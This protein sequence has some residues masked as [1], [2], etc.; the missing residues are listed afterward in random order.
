M[1]RVLV[2][3][4]VS[5]LAT[6]VVATE[7]R[8]AGPYTVSLVSPVPPAGAATFGWTVAGTAPDPRQEITGIEL[9]GCWTA[10]QV[11]SVEARDAA[12]ASLRAR[13][14][15]GGRTAGRIEVSG[16]SDR[17]L[18]ATITATFRN[19]FGSAATGTAAIIESGKGGQTT[20]TNME[21]G[22]PTCRPAYRL[23]LSA[24]TGGRASASP[25]APSYAADTAVTITAVPDA[26]HEFSGWTVDG[27]AG[28]VANP[29]QLTMNADRTV[30]AAFTPSGPPPDLVAPPLDPSVPTSVFD[31]TSFLY[32]GPG[33]VQVGVAPGTIQPDRVAVL[34]GKVLT[35]DGHPLPGARITVLDHPEFGRTQSRADG[36]FDLA[37]N[38]GG[39]L[40]LRYEMAGVI[41]AQRHVDAPW[42]D[43]ASLPD[44]VLVP[45]DPQVT[46]I[47]LS[48]SEPTQVARGTAVVD[49]SG[50]RQATLVFSQGTTAT[51]KMPD[52]S[53]QPLASLD[54]R[55]TELTVGDGG[56]ERMPSELP[57]TSGYTYA[58]EFS[59]DA[60]V[61]AGATEVA[62][63][64]PVAFYVDNFLGFPAG[65]D[66]PVGYYDRSRAAWVPAD[67]GR[68][69]AIVGEND[70][71]A[72]VDVNG[73]GAADDTTTLAELG[74][75]DAER[76]RLAD[77]Y[78]PGRSLWRA[79][80]VH[81]SPYD[82]N[83]P[84]VPPPDAIGPNGGPPRPGG[85]SDDD[86]PRF[87]SIISCL[88]QGL[89][90]TI[91]VV[92]TPFSLN[93]QS[94]QTPGRKPA[95]V[96]P[97]SGDTIPA[98]VKYIE[99][100]VAVAG[101][102]FTE[103]FPPS[104]GASVNFTWDGK[105][106]YGR[107][108]QGEQWVSVEVAYAYDGVY[109]SPDYV[110]RSWAQFGTA[111]TNI[112]TRNEVAISEKW[113]G[114]F[115]TLDARA[116]GLGGWTLSAHHAYDP[117]SGTLH[118][119]N[120][121][122]TR[123]ATVHRVIDT[124]AGNGQFGFG[125]DGE[126]AT[127]A[128]L[129]GPSG[130]VVAPDGS[131]YV[132]D[133][134][135]HRVR[136]V[137]TSGVITT[138]AGTGFNGFSGDG[139]PATQAT[140]NSPGPLALGPDG[141][142]YVGDVLNFRIRR[143]SP[144]GTITTF[145]GGGSTSSGGGVPA[146]DFQFSVGGLAVGPDGA[147]YI[148][149]PWHPGRVFKVSLDGMIATVAGSLTSTS[150]GD[151][152]PAT[153]ARLNDPFALAVDSDGT[154][155]IGENGQG[156]TSRPR[157]RKVGTDGVISTYAGGGTADPGDGRPATE[158]VIPTPQGLAI[159]PDG[160]YIASTSAQRLRL[161]TRD[162]I[163]T[164][165]AGTGQAGFAGDG[166][167]AGAALLGSP[168]KV[169]VAP[170]G[171]IYFSESVNHRVRR[172][173][174]PLAGVGHGEALVPAPDGE[175]VFHFDA[176]GRHTRTLDGLTGAVLVQFAYDG[177]GRLSGVTDADG[178]VTSIDRLPDGGP[179]AIVAPGGQRTVLEVN[180][181]GYLVRVANP[182]N[183]AVVL[184]YHPGGL[185]ATLTEPRGGIHRYTYDG[186]GRLVGDEHP[187]GGVTTLARTELADGHRVTLRSP[188][189]L[190]TTYESHRTSY[191]SEHVTTDPAGAGT[192]NRL[193]TSSGRQEVTYPDGRT[194]ALAVG[195][196]PRFGMQAP[197]T[198]TMTVRTPGGHEQTL[199]ASRSV[200][201]A[202]PSDPL[203]L[204]SLT[205]TS[206]LDGRTST[207][208]YDG[209]T[210]TLTLRTPEGRE[211]SMTFDTRANVTA[212]HSAPGVDPVLYTY[213]PTGLLTQVEAGT[214]RSAYEYD[215][216]RRP[217]RRTGADGS[218]TLYSY[219][220]ADRVVSTTAP[221]GAV[222]TYR[223]DANGNR[224]GLT[225]PNGAEHRLAYDS[226]NLRSEYRAPGNGPEAW[227]HD[228]DR[229]LTT[230]TRP[231]G[232]SQV[233]TFDPGGRIDGTTTP[234]ASTATAYSDGTDRASGA[235]R[236]PSAVGMGEEVGFSYDGALLT[237]IDF[238]GPA[239]LG[240]YSYSHDDNGLVR[241]ARFDSG[242]QS[243]TFDV[244]RDGDGLVTA[245]GP[246][247]WA[248]GGPGG[249]VS[250]VS[251]GTL[252]LEQGYDG[253][254]NV[255]DRRFSVGGT[256]RYR[257]RSTFDDRALI[258]QRVET[259][260]GT[261]H[262]FEYVYDANQQLREVKR[263]AATVERYDYDV[264]ANRTSRQLG[265][266]PPE[267]AVYDAQDR[268]L[269]RG[270]V[271]YQVDDDGMLVR[272]GDDTF[273]YGTEGELVS[274]HVGDRIL[275]YSY[276]ALGRRVAKEVSSP[277]GQS[278][279]E[280]LY[281]D[282]GDPLLVTAVRSGA[283]LTV[284]FH[285][286]AGWLYAFER[287]GSRY[288]VASDHVGS[289]RLVTTAAGDVVKAVEYDAFGGVISDSNPDF[290]LPV[291]FAG[292]LADAEAG[293]VHFGF[294]DY[295]PASGRW[296]ARDPALFAGGQANLYAYVGNS[297]VT[298][299]D[300]SGLWCIGGSVYATVGVGAKVCQDEKGWTVCSEAGVG[301]GGGL[302]FD[303][304]GEGSN[305]VNLVGEIGLECTGVSL[306]AGLDID[307]CGKGKP[308]EP[309]VKCQV[310]LY[311]PCQKKGVTDG[312]EDAL[313]AIKPKC[314]GGGKLAIE[315]CAR[316]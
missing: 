119:G 50:T 131:L 105:D 220:A 86:C 32:S 242:G 196:D 140:L 252:A 267:A 90:E 248:R 67:D 284:L 161:V 18:P 302:E 179:A 227:V 301:V 104:A 172:I 279:V 209:A 292:G 26:G 1:R 186:L 256:E 272:R 31:A 109:T 6:M 125:G 114:S 191:G 103:S 174:R 37:V 35:P 224:T 55:A 241:Q 73:D 166:G 230:H 240:R 13:V 20:S 187:A 30:V 189:G 243:F 96:V 29:L 165:V 89:G 275:T 88:G 110:F 163:I 21:V 139:G 213:G 231:G 156:F 4:A 97:L 249:A 188:L 136:R 2:T 204:Q 7:A 14:R 289:P 15:G 143:I 228:L 19:A 253:H 250:R 72:D 278:R 44:V 178:N 288:Y 23:N 218:V 198:T 141:S 157:V 5:L 108:P 117:V 145:A 48:S 313:H 113:T 132:A 9:S 245:F 290:F 244:G 27:A 34:R 112:P 229:R 206:T 78:D 107:T 314:G 116:S 300:P 151:G 95:L 153:Q 111:L 160:L 181:D 158:A 53:T 239:S 63:S 216:L 232:R 115:G 52:G 258:T 312:F 146:T 81:F 311:D 71:Q 185:L 138:V 62:F 59:V 263:D 266:A 298:F 257:L 291:G 295:E 192:V 254:A 221:N 99:L 310:V 264:N 283:E 11:A 308:P 152:G 315:A 70:G 159:G 200:T 102:T 197:R 100:T 127:S 273:T 259:V 255:T 183:E 194:V 155:Y 199:S 60:A 304:F 41:P 280:Y 164:T 101:R 236:T 176:D 57:P 297:P 212:K 180:G 265:S 40:T 225:M 82:L 237:S 307:L 16:V 261:T 87:S 316:I 173:T 68:V 128:M 195:P 202:N 3:L 64:K 168:M 171:A 56:P 270:A 274:A 262:T 22:G 149:E 277:A 238:R 271:A 122:R 126:A 234:E 36:M 91:D 137:D 144:G 93:Y 208:S 154:L 217:V 75:D 177:A 133:S 79:R 106:A 92:G 282:P 124:V 66:V 39:R 65:T 83:F 12:G 25:E 28:G 268:L 150:L 193:F 38:G 205:D 281:G 226:M 17:R 293:L 276:D 299:R 162:G 233:R 182:A 120:G 219:D 54:V 47:D 42:E 305:K 46:T 123:A 246:F 235:T 45:F 207:R 303:P 147:V 33:A 148:S 24:S 77:L 269:S 98:S 142:L 118:Y 169:D 306:G 285:D 134:G 309:K 74:L 94:N 85:G 129:R 58:A 167:P 130:V 121:T 251:G 286:D 61:S 84:Y 222:Y 287:A 215:A 51:M 43:F 201:L 80:V 294:R 260:S 175:Q 10:A 247:T 211:R 296:T 8:A 76:A 135:N 210:R 49:G 203:S 184:T 214:E 69:I 223:Y 190:V 170:D